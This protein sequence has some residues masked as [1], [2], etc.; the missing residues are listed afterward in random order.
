[1]RSLDTHD[2]RLGLKRISHLLSSLR[3]QFVD[4][5][6][7]KDEAPNKGESTESDTNEPL[8]NIQMF[9][10]DVEDSATQVT[11]DEL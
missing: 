3:A 7:L 10:G 4:R 6:Q 8:S 2:L 5:D 1:V 11:N 9:A